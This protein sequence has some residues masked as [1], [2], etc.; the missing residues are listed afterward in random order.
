[1]RIVGAHEE[2]H[3]VGIPENRA[4]DKL[5]VVTVEAHSSVDPLGTSTLSFLLVRN[6]KSNSGIEEAIAPAKQDENNHRQNNTNE[7]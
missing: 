3:L 6:S 1:V 5:A 2:P 7:T 4:P